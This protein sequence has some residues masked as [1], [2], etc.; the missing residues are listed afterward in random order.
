[1]RQTGSE[2]GQFSVQHCQRGQYTRATLSV[3]L[4]STKVP[5]LF[6]SN[7]GIYAAFFI[8]DSIV[9]AMI[10]TYWNLTFVSLC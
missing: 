6:L 1:M 9:A 3:L 7:F 8:C 5:L 10:S 2:T 4:V